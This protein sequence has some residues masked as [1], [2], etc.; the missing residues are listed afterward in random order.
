MSHELL[1]AILD[2][3]WV[4]RTYLTELIERAGK[5]KVVGSFGRA[6][7]LEAFL[8]DRSTPALDAVFVDIRLE[9]EESAGIDFVRKWGRNR[10]GG[11]EFIFATAYPHHALEA[12]ELGVRDYLL[13][14]YVLERVSHCL[15]RIAQARLRQTPLMP[16]KLVARRKRN[17]VF[18]DVPRIRAF[19]A[20]ERFVQVHTPDGVFESDLSL[21]VLAETFQDLFVRTHRHWL[22]NLSQ[23]R[24]MEREDGETALLVGEE[25][26]R[27][28]VSRDRLAA[29]RELLLAAPGIRRR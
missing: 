29:V 19:E 1:T 18:L 24:E 22:V 23:V 10:K 15:E 3:E 5:A 4:A 16:E 9:P 27:A 12:F 8:S 17:L 20:V 14:P 26:L 6:E 11:P 7:E 28:P 13:K 25:R 2:D 21:A